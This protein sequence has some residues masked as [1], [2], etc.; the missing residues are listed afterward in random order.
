[1]GRGG[2]WIRILVVALGVLGFSGCDDRGRK[3]EGGTE[4]FVGVCHVFDAEGVAWARG[5][6]TNSVRL[7]FAWSGVESYPA[8]RTGR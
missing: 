5:L 6:G 1:M 4:F 3:P 8:E 7:G 2:W